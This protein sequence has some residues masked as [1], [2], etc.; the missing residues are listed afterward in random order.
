VKCRRKAIGTPVAALFSAVA[1]VVVTVLAAF[2]L[3]DGYAAPAVAP[4]V[5]PAASPA[6]NDAQYIRTGVLV[7][8]SPTDPVPCASV[9]ATSQAIAFNEPM[10]RMGECIGLPWFI[11]LSPHEV[12]SRGF[13]VAQQWAY[14]RAHAQ[15]YA[16]VLFDDFKHQVVIG[17]LSQPLNYYLTL[18]SDHVPA[19]VVAYIPEGLPSNMTGVKCVILA[20]LGGMQT[21]Q[22]LPEQYA[23]SNL[24]VR[25]LQSI[26]VNQ[27]IPLIYPHGSPDYVQ[28][29][30]GLA[31]PK[32]NVVLWVPNGSI[33]APWTG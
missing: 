21:G 10:P 3:T 7:W 26:D 19:C 15:E 27:I 23:W 28:F 12:Q 32:G 8:Q 4:M 16:G 18:N 6:V 20:V 1:A 17:N 33:S 30:Q 13:T 9:N 2:T 11:F 31:S 29:M 24:T 14:Y 25:N 22:Y 5:A